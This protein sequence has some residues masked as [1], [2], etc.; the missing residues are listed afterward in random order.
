MFP[1]IKVITED[2]TNIISQNQTYNAFYAG[3]FERGPV[4][5]VVQVSSIYD[6]KVT[7]GKP[8]K[9]NF[10]DWFQIYNYFLY[11]N[12]SIYIVRADSENSSKANS[13]LGIS[14]KYPGE[15]GNSIVVK[16]SKSNLKVYLNNELVD[17]IGKGSESFYIDYPD[18]LPD[19][20]EVRLSGG[21]HGIPRAI[22]I[23][24]A[25]EV[26]DA[27]DLDFDFVLANSNYEYP[28]IKL[29]EAKLAIAFVYSPVNSPNAICYQGYKTQKSIF[30]GK[31]YNIP[32]LGDAM[33]LRA[34]LAN[35]VGISESHCK[36]SYSLTSVEGANILNLKE[37]YNQ[38]IN[39]IARNDSSY[40]FYSETL[41]DGSQFTSQFI[42]NRLKKETQAGSLYFVFENN[43]EFTRNDYQ[44]KL[45]AICQDYKD[46]GYIADYQVICND[47]NQSTIEPNTIYADI[48]VKM[49]GV[50]EQVL[51]K[52]KATSSL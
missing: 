41:G 40:Y 14:A 35:E 6:F 42:L 13:Q 15:Y 16:G 1:E 10:E 23:A 12:K 4:G 25:Y 45:S 26:G 18:E 46:S 21:F 19:E 22:D 17:N 43:D 49:N 7:F 5:E 37:L 29:A 28:A 44:K 38:R 50:I 2:F 30:N 39:S 24:D 9:S 31:S 52:L 11:N 27:G 48:A 47:L 3:H 32:I 34:Q 51:I 36:R 8:M 20:F 33:G